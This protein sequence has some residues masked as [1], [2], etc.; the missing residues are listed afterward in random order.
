MIFFIKREASLETDNNYKENINLIS[1]ARNYKDF[2]LYRSPEA[3]LNAVSQSLPVLMLTTFFGPASA[4]FYTLGKTVLSAPSQLLAKSVT[5]VFY[6]RISEAANNGE[7][8]YVLIKRATLAL[9][10]V[11]LIPFGLI[12]LFAPYMFGIIFGS[13]WETAGEYTRWI[14]VWSYIGF[15]NRPSVAAIPVISAQLFFLKYSICSIVIRFIALFLG[16]LI[17]END[18]IAIA[19]FSI[20]SAILNLILILSV[21]KK[22]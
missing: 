10:L 19:M 20:T 9:A 13:G 11:G 7:N 1:L 4:G 18:L 14:A 21:S 8:L 5:D 3:L 17:Y 12:F 2:P 22:S 16:Y 6:P 15:L